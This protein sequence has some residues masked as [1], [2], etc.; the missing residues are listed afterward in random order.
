MRI[1]F[2]LTILLASGGCTHKFDSADLVVHNAKIYTIDPAFSTF[3]AMAVKGGKIVALGPD[4]KILNKYNYTEEYDA[5]GRA[6]FPGFMDAHCHFYEYGLSLLQINLTG[7]KSFDEVLAK[8]GDYYNHFPTKW[9]TGRGWNQNGDPENVFPDRR[10]LD[11]LFP[12]IPVLL[13]HADGRVALANGE[14]LKRAGIISGGA[15]PG[16]EIEVKDGRLTGIL[17]HHAIDSVMRVIPPPTRA[18]QMRALLYAQRNC[19]SVGLTTV[20]DA[21]LEKEVV[22]LMGRMHQSGSLKMRIYAMLAARSENLEYFLQTGP[23]KT[24]RLNV[25]SFQFYTHG[26][27]NSREAVFRDFHPGYS[28]PPLSDTSCF[29][30]YAPL[31]YEKG[32]Q[33]HAHCTGDSANRYLLQ[34]YKEVLKED[35]NAR[36]RMEHAQTTPLADLH[37]FKDLGIVFSIHSDCGMYASGKH[38]QANPDHIRNAFASNGLKTGN[39]WLPLGSDFPAGD[40]DPIQTFHA[41]ISGKAGR[42]GAHVGEFPESSGLTRKDAIRGLTFW[43]AK[44][45]FE[46]LE[47]G[48]L[49]M[50]KRADFVVLDT[51]LMTAP[52]KDIPG[53]KVLATFIDGEKVFEY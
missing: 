22:E 34:L 47:K 53:A 35:K 36:W 39:G 1:L 20:N 40:I 45:N 3:Q 46:E 8:I 30:K 50:G 31:L 43:V 38:D 42:E 11:A 33:M 26:V 52:K 24:D 37:H 51:D 25:R 12:D 28:G 6:V 16:G 27:S 13:C 21:G 41:V 5:R 29:Q 18:E 17:I 32:F 10:K 19:F 9:I 14:A 15:V 4:R 2:L 7:T 44:S 49:E 48:S 23:V